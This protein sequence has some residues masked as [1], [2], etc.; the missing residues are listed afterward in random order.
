MYTVNWIFKFL[1]NLTKYKYYFV[2]YV[3]NKMNF[4]LFID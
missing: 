1:C 3:Y 2:D 4:Y